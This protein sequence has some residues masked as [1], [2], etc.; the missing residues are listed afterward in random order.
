[1][2]VQLQGDYGTTKRECC[3]SSD[4]F[5]KS[6]LSGYTPSAVSCTRSNRCDALWGTSGVS[7]VILSIKPKP[8]GRSPATNSGVLWK[9]RTKARP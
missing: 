4:P 7:E 9:T 8:K 2:T 6:Q 1:M 3:H 5:T